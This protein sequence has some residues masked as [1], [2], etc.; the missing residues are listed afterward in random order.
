MLVI[1]AFRIKAQIRSQSRSYSKGWGEF[2]IYKMI[3]YFHFGDL[4]YFEGE[5]L[6]FTFLHL[7]KTVICIS[8]ANI[9]NS[10]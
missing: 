5:A 4:V 10:F 6:V 7:T 3:I 2:S 1:I 9:Q 8:T